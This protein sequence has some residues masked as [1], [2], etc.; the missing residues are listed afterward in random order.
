MAS[1][2]IGPDESRRLLELARSD[3]EAASA[4]LARL[5]VDDQLAVVCSAPPARRA[6]LLALLPD[7]EALIPRLP[8]AELVFTVKAVG[9]HDAGWILACATSEQII[10]GLDLDAWRGYE[11][12]ADTLGEWIASLAEADQQA[13]VRA[14]RALDPELLVIYLRHRLLVVQKPDDDPG[15]QPP[16]Q[17]QTLE[18]QF[19]FVTRDEGD[20]AEALVA[21]LRGL[22]DE[23][24][25]TYFR[26]MQGAIWE[27]DSDTEEWALRWRTGRLQDLGFPPWDEAMGIYRFIAPEDRA[28][29]PEAEQA[30]DVDAWKLPVWLPSLPDAASS[31]HRVFRAIAALAGDERR[32]AYYAFVAVANKIA[33]ADRMPLSDVEST[34]RA[35]E[36]AAR[37]ISDGIAHVGAEHGLTDVDVLRRLTLERLFGI[38]ANLDPLSARP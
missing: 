24:Y 1:A 13:L 8:E 30:L 7:P 20:D 3:R 14:A 2:P 25:W 33:V 5:P 37:F 4:S 17:A 10:A 27:L 9:L 29:V 35:I 34:P 21:L 19:Y 18:G 38:G 23:D 31:E 26:L 16:D 28:R 12:D 6:A 22:F 11:V 32:A 36:K 15:W